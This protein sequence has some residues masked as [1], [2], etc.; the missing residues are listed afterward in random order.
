MPDRAIRFLIV[1]DMT[2][3]L[4]ALE[5][6]LRRDGLEVH[7]AQSAAE[8]LE[9]L[10]VNDYALVLLDVHM[11]ETDGYELAELMR[12]AERTRLV[13]II[14]VTAVEKDETRRFRGYEAGAVD[15]IFKPIDPVILKSKAEVF[16]RIGQQARDL[17]KQ[18][19]EMRAI[20]QHRDQAMARLKA[21]TDN[22]PLG[23]VE[24][25]G[26]LVMRSWSQ[27]AERI[28]SRL[29]RDMLGQTLEASGWLPAEATTVLKGWVDEH[30]DS[31]RSLRHS[32]EVVARTADGREVTCEVYGSVLIEADGRHR[33][34]SLQ[35]LDITAR[36]QA[37]EVRSLLIGELNHRIKNTL[38]NVQA[39]ARQTLRQSA[40]L[41]EFDRSFSGRLQALARAH[42]ILSDA[43]WSS[44]PLDDLIEDHI[45]AG[46]LAADRL[47]RTGPRVE[48]SPENMLRMALT[49]HELTTN[50]QKYG[51]LSV[52]G[53]EIH[54]DWALEG[55]GL[56]LRWQEKGGPPVTAPARTGFGLTLIASSAGGEEGTVA[57]EWSREG[58][59]WTIRL[60]RG[61]SPLK[62]SP[63]AAR[64]DSAVAVAAGA[65][66]A[67]LH[68]LVVEDEPLVVL[69]LTHEIEDAG[70]E[71]VAVA[72]TLSEALDT[73]SGDGIDLAILDGNLRGEKVD[74]VAELLAGRDIPFCFVSGYGPEHL[75]SAF[76]SV[77]VIQ[78]PFSSA[79]LRAVL[80]RLAKPREAQVA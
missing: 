39:I 31:D 25:D 29:A 70:A 46:T 35:V 28:F 40:D 44:A 5:A 2:E 50:A 80:R 17:A 60:L 21:H 78:K 4:M 20:A 18:R 74:A 42:S 51:A 24:L 3:N 66:L 14:F 19:D 34:L 57:A 59:K 56:V 71:V 7:Q 64:P 73:A 58:V 36:R 65:E 27:G 68:V 67:G 38:A 75:P 15:F 26:G 43:T 52:P 41:A 12:G 72:R 30:S 22:S 49:L 32:L 8:A 69:D 37:E 76:R 77:P 13:P 54:L 53:G 55:E 61:V 45:R 63:A 6:L 1:D 79:G 9:L 47:R 48:I 10:H 23:F 62:G 33:S 16:F 11:P